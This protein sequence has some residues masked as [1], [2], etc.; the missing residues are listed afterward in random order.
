MNLLEK[1]SIDTDKLISSEDLF[2]LRGGVA[3]DPCGPWLPSRCVCMVARFFGK[4]YS[5]E[6]LPTQVV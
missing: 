3:E 6:N 2:A 5:L 1:L 4:S